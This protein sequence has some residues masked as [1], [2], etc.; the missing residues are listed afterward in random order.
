[1]K[2]GLRPSL[3]V[4][5]GLCLFAAAAVAAEAK[6]TIRKATKTPIVWSAGEINWVDNPAMKG[7]RIAVLWGDPKTG[8]YGALKKVAAGTDLGLHTHTHDQ[9]V[10]AISGTFIAG[11]EGGPTKELSPGSYLFMPAGVKHSAKCQPASDCVY[12]EE[13][14]GPSDFKPAQPTAAKK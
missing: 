4:L 6:G 1:M 7:A 3:L 8:A 14:P 13:Q 2:Q 5:V 11:L 9:R 10:L 12:F